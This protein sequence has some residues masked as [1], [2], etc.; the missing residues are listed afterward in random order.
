M[1]GVVGLVDA[2][3]GIELDVPIEMYYDAPAQNLSI[4]Y[5]PGVQDLNGQQAMEVVRF[6]KNADGTGYADSDIGR[7]RTQQA[8]LMAL[9]DK[10]ISWGSI[11]R[12]NEYVDI[13]A[14]SVE[15]N[16]PMRDLLYFSSNG[17]QLGIGTAVRT[18]TLPGAGEFTYGGLSGTAE[19]VRVGKAG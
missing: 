10:V 9:A 19:M 14:R 6:R 2:V 12:T 8:F 5:L 4:H 17:I 15:S 16:M 18:G 13:F 1:P 11:T 7:T 3:G